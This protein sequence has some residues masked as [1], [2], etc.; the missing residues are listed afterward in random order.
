MASTPDDAIVSMQVNLEQ[1]T[2]KKWAEWVRIAR[3]TGLAKHGEI[4][5]HLK[6]EHGLGHG[7]ANMIALETREGEAPKPAEGDAV[8]GLYAGA[9]AGLRPIHDALMAAIG[10]LGSDF[11]VSPKKGYLSLRRKKQFALIQP[12]T[13]TRLDLG[14]QLKGVAPE[15]RLEAAGSWSGMVSHRV[16]LE[17]AKEIDKQLVAW[18]RTAFDAAG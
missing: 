17:S 15:G 18:L 12:S 3:A 13:A 1:K 11:E 4:V 14:L 10:K 2:G 8:E 16:R 6:S 7:Y 9:K 5:K